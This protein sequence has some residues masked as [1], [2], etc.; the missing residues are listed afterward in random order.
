[1][2]KEYGL[3]DETL[4]NRKT[5]QNKELFEFE[6]KAKV[7]EHLEKVEVED[8]R[9]TKDCDTKIITATTIET[10][11]KYL[12]LV[13][14]ENRYDMDKKLNKQWIQIQGLKPDRYLKTHK[15]A[16]A[17][18]AVDEPASESNDDDDDSDEESGDDKK[19]GDGSDNDS[20]KSKD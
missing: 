4:K 20:K 3:E 14:G 10:L 8:K 5:K 11:M 17:A 19:S 18:G 7:L 12:D 1:M 9:V 13:P 16:E 6:K 15:K 2:I